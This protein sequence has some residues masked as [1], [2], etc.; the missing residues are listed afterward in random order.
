MTGWRIGY[1]AGPASMINGLVRI[2]QYSVMS[3][4]TVSQ[5]GALEA[6]SGRALCQR[7]VGG[8]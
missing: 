6:Q 7:D 3:A 1:A 2:H 8:V 5:Y 4:P